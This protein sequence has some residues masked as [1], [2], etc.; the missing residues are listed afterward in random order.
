VREKRESPVGRWE[1]EEKAGVDELLEPSVY[2]AFPV[3][4]API[5]AAATIAAATKP[6]AASS[7]MVTEMANPTKAR[8]T[9]P[10]KQSK[11]LHGVF[12][13]RRSNVRAHPFVAS[14]GERGR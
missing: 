8:V 4:Y 13:S 9:P 2:L 11:N 3:K 10:A 7:P 6:P 1:A 14:E 12:R 5:A